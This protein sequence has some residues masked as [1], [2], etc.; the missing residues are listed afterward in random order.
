MNVINPHGIVIW[1]NEQIAYYQR[2][3]TASKP[4]SHW[5]GY[6]E[7]KISAFQ[8]TKDLIVNKGNQ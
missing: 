8:A 5:Q 4:G 1:L 7:G 2:E 3:Y 6:C